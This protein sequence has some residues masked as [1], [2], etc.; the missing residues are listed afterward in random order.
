MFWDTI[1]FNKGTRM[2]RTNITADSVI[3]EVVNRIPV[4]ENK[5]LVHLNIDTQETRDNTTTIRFKLTKE[6]VNTRV[7]IT[8]ILTIHTET[9]EDQEK[10][11]KILET[12]KHPNPILASVIIMKTQPVIL[13]IEE[14]LGV[15]PIPI[16]PPDTQEEQP[17]KRDD[18]VI[19]Q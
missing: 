6:T 1:L 8:G 7:S 14:L 5:V 10:L 13:H 2:I 19:Y 3:A 11:R 12:K 9:R 4:K 17:K 15:P 16:P 18:N